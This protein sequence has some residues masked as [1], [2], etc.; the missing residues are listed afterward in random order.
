MAG[1]ILESLLLKQFLP[2]I[3]AGSNVPHAASFCAWVELIFSNTVAQASVNGGSVNAGT[4][5]PVTTT[6]PVALLVQLVHVAVMVCVPAMAGAVMLKF[7]LPSALVLPCVGLNM[8]VPV[9]GAAAVLL[10]VTAMPLL[11][12]PPSITCA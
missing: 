8:S 1:A 5:H 2:V 7:S 12:V 4:G 10:S 6:V 3:K 11:G 9:A